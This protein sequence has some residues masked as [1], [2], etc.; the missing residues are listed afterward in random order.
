MLCSCAIAKR[1][2]VSLASTA[3]VLGLA[4]SAVAQQVA[5]PSPTWND[6]LKAKSVAIVWVS[7]P[8]SMP[9]KAAQLTATIRKGNCAEIV[10]ATKP[11]HSDRLPKVTMTE[12]ARCFVRLTTGIWKTT[13]MAAA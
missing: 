4:F 6:E 9:E 2:S 11:R 13:P 10:R 12:P 3:V 8:D 1:V 5:A 7:G